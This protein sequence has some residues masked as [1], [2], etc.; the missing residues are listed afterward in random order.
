[1]NWTHLWRAVEDGYLDIDK[2]FV[3][4]RASLMLGALLPL[5]WSAGYNWEEGRRIA[6]ALPLA[7]D[8]VNADPSLL[9]GLRLQLLPGWPATSQSE[10]F[11]ALDSM[12]DGPPALQAFDQASQYGIAAMIGPACSRTPL[13]FLEHLEYERLSNAGACEQ[14]GF[15][16]SGP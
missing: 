16:A 15:L 9:P 13:L 7:V 8:R 4:T 2:E 12:C 14:T 11:Q 1:M 5:S 10:A 6:G 3:E